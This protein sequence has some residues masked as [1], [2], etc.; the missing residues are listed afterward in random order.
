MW[1]ADRSE[2]Q[3]GGKFKIHD[4]T[5]ATNAD[6][7]THSSIANTRPMTVDELKAELNQGWTPVERRITTKNPDGTKTYRWEPIPEAERAKY[8]GA[9][10]AKPVKPA[11]APK[12]AK[13][14]AAGNGNR[15][16]GPAV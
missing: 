14:Q 3:K 10:P 11:K 16:A 9:P 13:P 15:R 2:I 12:P 8:M 5:P 1:K 4:D 7:P 6:N